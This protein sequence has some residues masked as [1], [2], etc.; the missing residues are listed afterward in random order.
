VLRAEKKK[1]IGSLIGGVVGPFGAVGSVCCFL[2][3]AFMF[4]VDTG[5]VID[6]AIVK[7]AVQ[8]SRPALERH[9]P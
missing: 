2:E 8:P 7:S 5:E 9:Q 6:G 4:R 3:S 1:R